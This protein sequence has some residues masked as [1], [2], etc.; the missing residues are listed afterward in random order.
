[1]S[2]EAAAAAASLSSSRSSSSSSFEL[3]PEDGPLLNAQAERSEW[4]ESA[5]DPRRATKL[6]VFS[7]WLALAASLGGFMFGYDSGVVNGTYAG[8]QS[9]YQTSEATTALAV[10]AVLPGCALGAL[11]AGRLADR[12]GRRSVL[13]VAAVLFVFSALCAGLAASWP[14]FVTQ[15]VLGGLAVGAAS[16]ICPAYIA[17]ISQASYRGR[18][19]SLQ[20]VNI[21]LGMT[22]A[23]VVNW[24]LATTA[25]SAQDTLWLSL[26][27]WRWMYVLSAVP[28]LLFL[29]ALL[30]VPESPRYLVFKARHDEALAILQRLEEPQDARRKVQEIVA[31]IAH[32]N[33]L[34]TDLLRAEGEQGP[35]C[36]LRPTVWAGLG[37]ASFQQLIG[38]NVVLYYGSVLWQAVGFSEASSLLINIYSGCVSLL[39]QTLT[40]SLMDRLGRKTLLQAGSVLCCVLLGLTAALF[41]TP[42]TD[43]DGNKDNLSLSPLASK[44]ALVSTN[45]YVFI[46]Q[47]TWGPCTWV[48]L[49]EVFPN[50]IR[51]SGL[52][53]AGFFQWLCNFLITLSFPL[54]LSSIG[55]VGAY[56]LYA[57]FALLSILFVSHV[58]TETKGLPL[59]AM[60]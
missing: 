40:L 31:S 54:L 20:H 55:L 13:R 46:F 42:P 10:A 58:L 34:W 41:S 47:M 53:L 18:L 11:V 59:E 39:A 27:A 57:C 29:L 7:V 21:V 36:W 15:R 24:L 26:A 52:A 45:L 1:M 33:P 8:L 3:F 56:V 16:V 2:M 19:T 51:G 17:E 32:E 4:R 14:W 35:C 43:Q 23:Y 6:S 25:G 5:G 60:R 38:I 48:V 44:L 49:G 12:W 28:G 30:A 50:Q 9:T 22:I 37:V